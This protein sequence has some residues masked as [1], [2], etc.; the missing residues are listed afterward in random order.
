MEPAPNPRPAIAGVLDVVCLDD[1]Q[2]G[3]DCRQPGIEWTLARL[4]QRR[5]PEA[6]QIRR[7]RQLGRVRAQLVRGQVVIGHTA[8]LGQS[9]STVV[10]VMCH[11]P[12][13]RV[14]TARTTW[15][16]ATYSPRA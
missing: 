2:P 8:I 12:A 15:N 9:P 4:G 14:I 3:L 1:R 11:I 6:V 7:H 13:W 5:R 16:R 10:A